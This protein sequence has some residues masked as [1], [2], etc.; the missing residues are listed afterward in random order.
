[1]RHSRAVSACLLFALTCGC[2]VLPAAPN[3]EREAGPPVRPPEP[4]ALVVTEPRTVPLPLVAE[5]PAFVPAYDV[6]RALTR[7]PRVEGKLDVK[8]ERRWSYIVIHHSATWVGNEA[9]F[10][11]HHRERNGWRG[12]GYDFVI[13]NGH[14]STDG[15]VEV[16]FRWEE[17]QD[18]AHAGDPEYNKHGIGI[19]LVGDFEKS[20]PTAKQ[21]EALVG[22]VNYL[23][24]RCRIPTGN[25]LLHRHVRPS[26]TRCP[27]RNFPFYDFI[28]LLEH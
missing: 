14:G 8:L 17:Q 10:D 21:M 18:G 15:L 19:C 27:G 22:L 5:T 9:V 7:P 2:T 25:V 16:T 13:G 23:Q 24:E 1:M 11:R 28:S 4:P 20:R 6:R 3:H 12:I 26:G